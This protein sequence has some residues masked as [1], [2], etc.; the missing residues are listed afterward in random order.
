M[1]STPIDPAFLETHRHDELSFWETKQSL[2]GQG[3]GQS[4]S[5]KDQPHLDYT[6]PGPG[7]MD[8]QRHR[9]ARV[10]VRTKKKGKRIPSF[11]GFMRVFWARPAGRK[12]RG[13]SR[14]HWK[15]YLSHLAW[16]CL[17]NFDKRLV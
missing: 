7:G 1:R 17:G 2:P 5:G 16:E 3:E 4:Q 12:P 6:W 10:S 13:R 11:L 15:D 14:T 9:E 8:L